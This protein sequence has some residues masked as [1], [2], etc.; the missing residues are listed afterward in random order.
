MSVCLACR[1]AAANRVV[2]FD[3]HFNPTV[4]TQALFRCYRFGQ[5]KPVYAYRLLP[6]GTGEEKVY[7]RSVNKSG[8]A[9]RVVDDKNYQGA[10]TQEE[11]SN[12][13]VNDTWV[14]E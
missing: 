7:S 9:M 8:L 10:F 6:E 1:R 12:M 14:S 3:S 2:L 13:A 4:M 11:L 5:T